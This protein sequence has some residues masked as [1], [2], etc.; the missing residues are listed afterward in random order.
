MEILIES[1]WPFIFIGFAVL[2]LLGW[3]IAAICMGCESPN[4]YKCNKCDLCGGFS[5]HKICVRS[6]SACVCGHEYWHHLA[7][8][9]IFNGND[10]ATAAA[11]GGLVAGLLHSSQKKE[12][13]KDQ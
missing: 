5:S 7:Y 1:N 9:R 6:R 2:G 3:A 10:N 12:V 13:K 11:A 4:R 8:P